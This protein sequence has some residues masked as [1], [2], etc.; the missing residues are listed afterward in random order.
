M[1]KEKKALGRGLDAL[2]GDRLDVNKKDALADATTSVAVSGALKSQKTINVAKLR[3]SDAQPRRY[4]NDELLAQL[5][6]SIKEHGILQ[7]LLVRPILG[8]AGSYEIIAGERRWRAAQKAQIHEVPVIIQDFTDLEALEIALIENIQRSDLTP[9]EE[10]EGYKR[11]MD[12]FGHTQEKLAEALGKSRPHIAN[13]MRLLK[14]PDSVR[15]QVHGGDLSAG[16]ARA[17]LSAKDPEALAQKVTK[18]GLNVRALEKLVSDEKKPVKVKPRP[19]PSLGSQDTNI[20]ALEKS[21]EDQ[22][23]LKVQITYDQKGSG[24]LTIKYQ[25]LDQLDDVLAKLTHEGY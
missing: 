1:N 4:F 24:S 10:A 6:S 12:E 25:N 14:L 9:I 11:L 18:E 19:A 21:L 2:F 16:H 8:E 22:I 15:K 13:M 23:G 7:P 3:P 5:S 20:K 17:L